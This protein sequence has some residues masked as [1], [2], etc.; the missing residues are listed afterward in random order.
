M[1]L[2]R[3][4]YDLRNSQSRENTTAQDE[5]KSDAQIQDEAGILLR[6]LVFSKRADNPAE[7][8]RDGL[9]HGRKGVEEADEEQADAVRAIGGA[10]PG[11]SGGHGGHG[12]SHRR[13]RH[14]SAGR[15]I[16]CNDGGVDVTG[17]ARKK[18]WCATNNG[19]NAEAAVC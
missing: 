7:G 19:A 4:L 10:R 14:L 6:E 8:K 13:C 12:S 3:S 11:V 9:D 2:Y 1:R 5:R 16:E 15:W 17:A 18:G